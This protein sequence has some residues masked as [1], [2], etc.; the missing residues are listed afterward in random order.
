MWDYEHLA[1]GFHKDPYWRIILFVYINSLNQ[2][3]SQSKLYTNDTILQVYQPCKETLT[4]QHDSAP[5]TP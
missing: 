3:F 5:E 2:E 4:L 1:M